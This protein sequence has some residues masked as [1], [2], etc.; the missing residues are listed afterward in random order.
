M[1][2]MEKIRDRNMN[3]R[4]TDHLKFS[5]ITVTLNAENEIETTVKSVLDQEY[6]SYEYI[7][8]DGASKDKTLYTC[9]KYRNCFESNNF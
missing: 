4:K 1:W 7:I 5:V 2:E 8:V 6:L 9:E 3:G